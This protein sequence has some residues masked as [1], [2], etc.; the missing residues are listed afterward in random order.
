MVTLVTAAVD[1]TGTGAV[2]IAI[3]FAFPSISIASKTEFFIDI[4]RNE[5]WNFLL[6]KKNGSLLNLKRA[7]IRTRLMKM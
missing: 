7:V 5:N 4:F 6:A 2:T 3:A 1:N